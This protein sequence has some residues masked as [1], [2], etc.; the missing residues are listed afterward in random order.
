M[1]LKEE[2]VGFIS[3]EWEGAPSGVIDASAGGQALLGLD[4]AIR[5]FNRRQ[6][7]GFGVTPYEIPVLTGSGS[8][9]AVVLGVIAIPATAFGMAYA[10]KAGEKMA[11]KD[12]ANIGFRD[13]ASRS[14][15]AL[16]KLVRLVKSKG[17]KLDVRKLEVT[18]SSDATEAT[19]RTGDGDSFVVPA[20]YLQWY[21]SLPATT[22]K[23]LTS[24]VAPGRRMT[25]GARQSDGSIDTVSFED[26]DRQLL[27]SNELEM[28]SEFLFPELEHGLEVVLEG[29]VTRG[30]QSTNS[31]GLQYQG[32]IL[33]CTP[34]TGSVKRFK[35]ALFEQCRVYATVNRHVSSLTALDYRPTLLVSDVVSL[36]SPSMQGGLF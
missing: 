14:M 17:G 13:V 10:K 18:W 26:R 4:D 12:F 9:I 24:P 35:P 32:H 21:S 34:E 36:E 30:N 3:Y 27:V 22:L 7:P 8:W 31:M 5:Y 19:I 11:E 28:E 6:S 2:G 1:T 23:R 16:V 15:D 25:V 33:N 20:E 29:I